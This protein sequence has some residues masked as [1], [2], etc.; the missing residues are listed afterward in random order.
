MKILRVNS[1]RK[2]KESQIT[3]KNTISIKDPRDLIIRTKVTSSNSTNKKNSMR[4][5]MDRKKK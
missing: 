4:K 1:F 3:T 5:K 2:I